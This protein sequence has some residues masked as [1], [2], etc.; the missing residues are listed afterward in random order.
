MWRPP[1]RLALLQSLLDRQATTDAV[2]RQTWLRADRLG[3]TSVAYAAVTYDPVSGIVVALTADKRLLAL[4]PCGHLLGSAT[5]DVRA[6]FDSRLIYERGVVVIVELSPALRNLQL[7]ENAN[8]THIPKAFPRRMI[9]LRLDCADGNYGPLCDRVCSPCDEQGSIGVS[10]NGAPLKPAAH[11]D[12]RRT[13]CDGG[14]FGSGACQCRRG[15]DG[16]SCSVRIGRSEQFRRFA[17]PFAPIQLLG[18]PRDATAAPFAAGPRA[19]PQQVH[20]GKTPVGCTSERPLVLTHTATGLRHRRRRA[21]GQLG[22]RLCVAAG[23]GR[24][25]WRRAGLSRGEQQDQVGTRRG[26]R[27]VAVVCWCNFFQTPASHT[28]LVS[29]LRRRHASA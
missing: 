4:D 21:R 20:S 8:L 22:R 5:V 14:L 23:H 13:Q 27:L 16:D 18:D 10:A 3:S 29:A 2:E 26:Q 28:Q 19:V 7:P 24:R 17:L 15:F 1:P 12:S 9:Q 11:N 25:V 6:P